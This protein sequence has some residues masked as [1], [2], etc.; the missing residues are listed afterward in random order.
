MV[1]HRACRLL[2]LALVTLSCTG[3]LAA[4]RVQAPVPFALGVVET[5]HSMVLG[6]DRV[7]NIA[8]PQG[9][10]PDSAARYPVI[11]LLDGSADEDFIHI[12][13]A[14]QFAAFPWVDWL[15]PS[16]VVG[17]ANVDRRRDLTGPTTIARDKAD[18]P[19][20]GG[21][22]A[23]MDFVAKEVIPF[24][25]ANYR[26]FPERTLIGQSFGGLF[27]TEV[28]LRRPW[29]FQHYIIVS[30]SLWWDNGSVLRIPADGLS[31]PD[32]GAASVYI[33]VG[34]EGREMEKPAQQLAAM[35]RKAHVPQVSYQHITDLDHATILHEAVLKAWRWR[36]EAR[37]VQHR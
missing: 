23:F 1:T 14:A 3:R 34:K 28:L 25:E 16:I 11:Y 8:L 24:V 19:T 17:I 20:T 26:T 15:R 10:N 31:A 36:K 35:A 5:I 32:I 18:F 6:E 33:A 13:G 30:P 22:A 9:Y 4:Q 21:S 29:L 37:M 7:L 12:V 2:A 27:A